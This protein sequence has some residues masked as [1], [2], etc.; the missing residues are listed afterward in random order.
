MARYLIPT[1]PLTYA[2]IFF[3]RINK[4]YKIFYYIYYP[5][6]SNSRLNTTAIVIPTKVGIQTPFLCKQETITF[7][8]WIPVF[9]GMT[10]LVFHSMSDFLHI[11]KTLVFTTLTNFCTINRS[12]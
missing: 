1:Q 12:I 6:L 7:K 4:I 5:K 11:Q 8:D 10:D 9:T 3:D 2:D